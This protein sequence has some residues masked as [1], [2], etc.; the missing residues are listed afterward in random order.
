MD[1]QFLIGLLLGGFITW[2][3]AHIYYRKSSNDQKRFYLKFSK[4][5]RNVILQ[6]NRAKLSVRDLNE[7]LKEKTMNPKS[8]DPL[9]YKACP[10]CGSKDL[11]RS[12]LT[13]NRRDETYWTITCRSCGWYDWT[14]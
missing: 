9:P 2:L 11:N 3:V 6:D 1:A 14:Q 5:V 4:D 13:D 12:E 10:K 8:R 7:L